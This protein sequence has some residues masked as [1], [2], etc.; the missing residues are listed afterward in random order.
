MPYTH[1][2]LLLLSSA[3]CMVVS[4]SVVD[5]NSDFTLSTVPLRDH[6]LLSNANRSFALSTCMPGYALQTLQ[7]HG[8]VKD[9]LSRCLLQILSQA[10]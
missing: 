9:P 6:W 4:T 10:D 3:L 7:D 2:C 5:A 8:L 1:G